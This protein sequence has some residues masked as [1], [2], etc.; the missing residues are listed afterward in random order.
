MVGVCKVSDEVVKPL[1]GKLV[2]N[3]VRHPLALLGA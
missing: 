2:D 3:A 1:V